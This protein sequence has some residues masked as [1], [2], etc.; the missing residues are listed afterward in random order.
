MN[1]SDLP[2]RVVVRAF[3][4]RRRLPISY[5]SEHD[6]SVNLHTG[7]ATPG[8]TGAPP[9]SAQPGASTAPHR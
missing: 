4:S 5:V 7:G 8:P 9:E 6:N 1:R 2:A 3:D